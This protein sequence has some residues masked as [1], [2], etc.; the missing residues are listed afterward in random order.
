MVQVGFSTG[1]RSAPAFD[2]VW[3]LPKNIDPTIRDELN[4]NISS[5]FAF[6]WNLCRYWL[7][8]PV[9]SDID[10]FMEETNMQPMNINVTA[11]QL[12]GKYNIIMD[13]IEFEF[14]DVQLAPPAGVVA[15]NY[16]WCVCHKHIQ[17][18]DL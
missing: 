4:A 2:W 8:S 13:D 5:G 10:K 14:T 6:F 18:I 3:N 15:K 12:N 17:N 1:S 11:G 9:I 7:P 16:V